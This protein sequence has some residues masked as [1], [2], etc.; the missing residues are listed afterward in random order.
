MRALRL[1]GDMRA[2]RG[3]P[4]CAQ[5]ARQRRAAARPARRTVTELAN[6]EARRRIVSEFGSTFFVEAA[7]GTGKTTA[8]VRRIVGL[9]SAGAAT[10]ARTVAVTFTE[11]AAGETKLRLRS[12][13]RLSAR[14]L[15]S[16]S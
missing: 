14:R 7:A 1:P 10:L 5:A 9:V 13:S 8:L 12:E 2:T 15:T 6:A 11:K 3:A 16:N 4:H